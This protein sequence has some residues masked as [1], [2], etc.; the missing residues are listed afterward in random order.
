MALGGV[1]ES[2]AVVASGA[3]ESG[4]VVSELVAARGESGAVGSEGRAAVEWVSGERVW[5]AREE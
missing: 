2:P 4:P 3:V 1:P 5:P